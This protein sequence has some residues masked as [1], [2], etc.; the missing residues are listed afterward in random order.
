MGGHGGDVH[1]HHQLASLGVGI[2]TSGIPI[3]VVFLIIKTVKNSSQ[4]TPPQPLSRD[5]LEEKWL[6]HQGMH[7]MQSARTFCDT[8]RLQVGGHRTKSAPKCP[9][10]HFPQDLVYK[11]IK[12]PSHTLCI[13]CDPAFKNL[14]NP[15]QNLGVKRVPSPPK[16]GLNDGSKWLS[17][18]KCV[19]VCAR[20]SVCV[21]VCMYAGG[22]LQPPPDHSHNHSHSHPNSV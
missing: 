17:V 10:P 20:V 13:P 6:G 3:N 14:R 7:L 8:K 5:P 18:D 21:S 1:V 16:M 22:E 12:K 19:C 9:K 2:S 11:A 4:I 15:C